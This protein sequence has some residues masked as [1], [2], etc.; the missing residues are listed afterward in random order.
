MGRIK[1]DYELKIDSK[2]L[3]GDW[4]VPLND[5]LAS[6]YMYN[7]IVFLE[8]IYTDRDLVITPFKKQ[9]FRVFQEAKY[10]DLKV[11]VLADGPYKTFKNNGLA[12]ANKESLQHF[13]PELMKVKECIE[14]TVYGGFKL[15]FDP[16][17]ETWT[18]Q[19][20]LPLNT[21]QTAD[22]SKGKSHSV[23]WRRFTREIIKT[24]NNNK[25]DIVFILLGA[26]AGYFERYI[27][28]DKHQ[29]YKFHHPIHSVKR[30]QDWNCPCFRATNA[31][32]ARKFGSEHGI[33]W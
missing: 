5:L 33:E 11:V 4:A 1:I 14:K 25:K 28:R 26:E 7:L 31:F 29:I 13:S 8:E 20:V 19:G 9:V 17:L 3:F 6:D 12:L 10:R 32:L 15:T 30:M 24:I 23:Y 21:S 22:I 16:T 27:D 18:D 2:A